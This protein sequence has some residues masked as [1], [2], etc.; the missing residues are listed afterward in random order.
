MNVITTNRDSKCYNNDKI[1]IHNCNE[2]PL[3]YKEVE[4]PAVSFGQIF[5]VLARKCNILTSYNTGA[6]ALPDIYIH[7]P[8][9]TACP[10]AYISGKALL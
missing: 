6:C 10:C 7:S 3:L 8:L 9:G 5:G 4:I 1:W 2:Y